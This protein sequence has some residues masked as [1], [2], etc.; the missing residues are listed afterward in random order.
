MQS[1]SMN[2]DLKYNMIGIIFAIIALI[3]SWKK[4]LFPAAIIAGTIAIAFTVLSS[5]AKQTKENSEKISE[6][7]KKFERAEDLINIKSDIKIL[8]RDVFKK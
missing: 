6:L 4:E 8:K 2:K 5:Y 7:Y 1:V 3:V